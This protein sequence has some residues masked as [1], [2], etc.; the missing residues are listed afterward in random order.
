MSAGRAGLET[1]RPTRA[2]IL[3]ARLVTIRAWLTEKT[4]RD[5]GM[6]RSRWSRATNAMLLL[7]EHDVNV[8]IQTIRRGLHELQ[9]AWNRPRTKPSR[10]TSWRKPL[11]LG[12]TIRKYSGHLLSGKRKKMGFQFV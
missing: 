7:E 11:W 12:E 5:F 8:S 9:L 6:C 4:P 2:K 3:A 1:T 10:K